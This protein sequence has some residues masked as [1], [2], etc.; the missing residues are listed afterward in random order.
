MPFPVPLAPAVIVIHDVPL[1]AVHAQP[2]PVA[3]ATV[4]LLAPA[5]TDVLVGE[6][7]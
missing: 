3:T 4:P 7:E 2:E 6:M 1:F 5:P